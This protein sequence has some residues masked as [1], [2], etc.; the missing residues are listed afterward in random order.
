MIFIL[1]EIAKVIKYDDTIISI[2]APKNKPDLWMY[3]SL[4]PTPKHFYEKLDKDFV[5]KYNWSIEPNTGPYILKEFSK[6]KFLLFER[7]KDW[8]AKDLKFYV[9]RFNIDR[10]KLIVIRDDNVAFEYFKK[11]EIDNYMANIPEIW[12]I[13]GKGELF[14]K[15]Y[16]HKIWFYTDTMQPTW[17]FSLNMDKEIFKDINLRYAFAH[18]INFE[19]LNRV[20]LR[21]DYERLDSFFTGYGEYTNKKIKARE[22]S[23]NKVEYVYEEIR[24]EKRKRWDM[25]KKWEKIFNNCFIWQPIIKSKDACFTG[26]SEKGRD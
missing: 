4:A 2:S 1:R 18:A 7:K 17:G 6:G 15:G 22:Y 24:M 23:I 26:R 10:F 14:D 5:K 8:W 13:K 16:I 9:N 12:H 20:V 25:G 11:G 3:I 19:K 21:G